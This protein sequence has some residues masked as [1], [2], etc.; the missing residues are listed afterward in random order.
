MAI[1]E[2]GCKHNTDIR[3]DVLVRDR[4]GDAITRACPCACILLVA[5]GAEY[6]GPRRRRFLRLPIVLPDIPDRTDEKWAR[7]ARRGIRGIGRGSI[8]FRLPQKAPAFEHPKRLTAA[9]KL[10]YPITELDRLLMLMAMNT[11]HSMRLQKSEVPN[12]P[13]GV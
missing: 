3:E 10:L 2:I 9:D 8:L 11:P 1:V 12:E 7:M 5:H 4:D 13:A 6:A